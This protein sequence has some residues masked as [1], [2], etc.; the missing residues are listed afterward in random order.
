MTTGEEI[1]LF[2]INWRFL[3]FRDFILFKGTYPQ[4]DGAV[5]SIT[6]QIYAPALGRA[7]AAASAKAPHRP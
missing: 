5:R 4:A 3:A 6:P 1:D 7:W 2:E